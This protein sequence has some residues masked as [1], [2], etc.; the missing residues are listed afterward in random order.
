MCYTNWFEVRVNIVAIWFAKTEKKVR[1]EC[2][3]RFLLL[4]TKNGKTETGKPASK[5]NFEKKHFTWIWKEFLFH[6]T[7]KRVGITY[8]YSFQPIYV[9]KE[10]FFGKCFRL[11]KHRFFL[12]GN[13]SS[14]ARSPNMVSEGL[15]KVIKRNS[16]TW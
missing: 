13:S 4:F 15:R 6:L 8:S 3:K 2:D 7:I 10:K 5:N 9:H 12:W 14:G 11:L 16:F 1:K